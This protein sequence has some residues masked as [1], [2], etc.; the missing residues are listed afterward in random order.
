MRGVSGRTSH[1]SR[2]ISFARYLRSLKPLMRYRHR[3]VAGANF[4][5]IRS[6]PQRSEGHHGEAQGALNC[7]RSLLMGSVAAFLPTLAR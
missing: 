6:L 1:S 3:S 7:T 4:L 2:E 5:G